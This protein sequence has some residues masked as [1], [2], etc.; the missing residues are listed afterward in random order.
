M[1][2]YI[3]QIIESQKL[4]I[5]NLTFMFCLVQIVMGFS[6]YYAIKEN[7]IVPL[8]IVGLPYLFMFEAIRKGIFGNFKK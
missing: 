8:I 2:R 3:N 4:F 7:S 5:Q 6:V 1:K